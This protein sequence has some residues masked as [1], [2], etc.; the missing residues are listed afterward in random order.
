MAAADAAL[1]HGFVPSPSVK[2]HGL[3]A[4]AAG[5]R[6]RL[7]P[8]PSRLGCVWVSALCTVSSVLLVALPLPWTACL[9]CAV[10]ILV[11]FV[12]G[13][14]YCTGRGVPALMHVGNDRRMTVTDCE[15]R[16]HSGRI[17]DDSF[18]GAWLTTIV[19]RRDGQPWWHAAT[20]VVVLPDMLPADDLRRLRV[21]LRYGSPATRG[22]TSDVD[23]G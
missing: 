2:P 17:L 18:V 7:A 14:W 5:A 16:S 22:T 1:Q 15:G 4:R 19:W 10:V 3:P 11:V 9:P 8:R 21:A 6:L 23:A 20:A 13:L 12:R